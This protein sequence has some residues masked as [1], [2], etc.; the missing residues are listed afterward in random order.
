MPLM[1]GFPP[2]PQDR[3]TLANWRTQPYSSWAFHH[4]RE[5]V[6]SAEISHAPDD[7]WTL[8][9]GTPL[10]DPA[11]IDAAV[12]GTATDALVVMHK[13]RVVHEI[14]RNGMGPSD[15]H[16]L[17]SVS[18]S[19]LG[20]LAGILAAK[21]LLDLAARLTDY[22]PEL[23]GTAYEGATV[24]QALDMQ[25]GVTFSEDYTATGGPIPLPI[26][27]RPIGTRSTGRA[28][29]GICAVSS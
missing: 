4:V 28:I 17:M 13:G 24:R 3:V 27:K 12:E 11:E 19:V 20:T 26:A 9:S 23:E 15:P 6:P 10:L 29:P 16:I 14:Y 21:G 2:A 1:Q 7:I 25:V 22:I 18:K 8:E 5:I